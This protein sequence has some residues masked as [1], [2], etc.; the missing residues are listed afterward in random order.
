MELSSI[1]QV[2]TARQANLHLQS[3]NV[4]EDM[5]PAAQVDIPISMFIPSLRWSRALRNNPRGSL[6]GARGEAVGL[7]SWLRM[8]TTRSIARVSTHRAR[9][10]VYS[11]LWVQRCTQM[12]TPSNCVKTF[13]EN[14]NDPIVDHTRLARTLGALCSTTSSTNQRCIP[15]PVHVAP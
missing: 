7:V 12:K 1:D 14:E 15:V 9:E 3:T 13:H 6:E 4:S 11:S 10:M 2:Q 5:R 8:I